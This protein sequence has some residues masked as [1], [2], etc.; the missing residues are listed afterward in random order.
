MAKDLTATESQLKAWNP[1]GF[2][3]TFIFGSLLPN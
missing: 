3:G 1:V 2:Q